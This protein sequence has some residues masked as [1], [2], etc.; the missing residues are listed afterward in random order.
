MYGPEKHKTKII[1]EKFY[2]NL[3]IEVESRNIKND[4]IIIVG[5]LMEN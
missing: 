2:H 4:N 3:R 5:D 1:R